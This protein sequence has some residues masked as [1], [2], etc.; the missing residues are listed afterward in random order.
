MPDY[1]SSLAALVPTIILAIIVLVIGIVIAYLLSYL[2]RVLVRRTHLEE[3]IAEVGKGGPTPY[4][5]MRIEKT[6]G[7][8]VF[9]LLIFATI[10]AVLQVLNT[11]GVPGPLAPVFAYIPRLFSA[12]I[13]FFV[14]WMI[15]TVLRLLVTKVLSASGVF[16]NVSQSANVPPENQVTIGQTI[17]NIVYWLVFLLFLPAILGAL[18]I[19]GILGPVQ[20]MVN[21]ILAYLPNILAAVVIFVIGYFVARIVRQIVTNLL[22]SAGADNFGRRAGMGDMAD[23][24]RLSDVIG[25]FLFILI[26]I[27]TTIAALNALNIPA[28]T[29]PAANLLNTILQALP[30]IFAALVILVIAYFIGRVLGRFVAEL[31]EIVHFNR[32][33]QQIGLYN[34]ASARQAQER[35]SL[36]AQRAAA[37]ATGGPA[38]Q[39][40]PAAT[41]ADFVGYLVTAG[42]VL[43]AILE[44]SQFLGFTFLATL[45]SSFIV[46][47]FQVL[48]GL[49]I[50]GI[51][52]YLSALADR[53][54]RGSGMSQASILAPVARAVIIVFSAALGLRQMG[55]ADS[56]V[57]LAFGLLLGAVAVA[58]AIA[59]GLGG[60]DFAHRQLDRMEDNITATYLIPVTGR[61]PGQGRS[62]RAVNL[63]RLNRATLPRHR[64][65]RP[66]RLCLKSVLKKQ[67]APIPV[68][69]LRIRSGRSTFLGNQESNVAMGD[70]DRASELRCGADLG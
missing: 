54:I 27:P 47:A 40:P 69:P 51:G 3:R 23:Q 55:I 19:Q 16:R 29:V 42:I 44:A 30:S 14:A 21:S 67:S 43:F 31:L 33:F 61:K 5:E 57:N 59:F 13:L 18:D 52:L 39:V 4:K 36:E 53:A 60:R 65:R 24:V 45:I 38:P 2:T 62:S 22:A 49:V 63:V 68:L 46:A 15:A 17:G 48:V 10:A 58:A 26:L 12:A 66:P 56:I 9:W 70:M 41:P 34:E 64:P 32:F 8:I 28:V 20:T 7:G 6:A 25:W 37:E 35:A 50:F 1:L 11:S